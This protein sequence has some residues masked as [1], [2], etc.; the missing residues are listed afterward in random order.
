[1]RVLRRRWAAWVAV[2]VL[3]LA[4]VVVIGGL[5]R[6]QVA[7]AGVD[8]GDPWRQWSAH[9]ET[10]TATIEHGALDA[11]LGIYLVKD[12]D[13][14]LTR[15]AYGRVTPDDRRALGA[16]IGM[17]EAEDIAAFNR[18][19]QF[20]YWVNLYN[21]VTLRLILDHYP[22]E[23]IR[24]INDGPLSAGPWKRELVTVNG[25]SLRLDD[26]EHR[27]L[28]RLWRE[29]RVHYAVNCASVGCPNLADRAYTGA[30]LDEQLDAGARA[31][32]N[33]P[34]GVTI[35]GDGRLIVSSLYDWFREDFGMSDEDVIEHLRTYADDDLT[36]ALATR[37]SIDGYRYNW[38]LNGA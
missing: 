34:R 38:A 22:I 37:T 3:A 25:Q 24:D 30:T 21:A 36:A 20:A 2:A 4:G 8:D 7:T 10:S 15:V 18:R 26:I 14:G 23:S 17:L 33:S 32:I 1:M 6:A 31:Y 35:D 27:I 5:G 13:G 11:F 29:P 19:E 16:Y 9:D 28:R 12:G